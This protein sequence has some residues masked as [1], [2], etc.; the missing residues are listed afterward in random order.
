MKLKEAMNIRVYTGLSEIRLPILEKLKIY[1]FVMQYYPGWLT[2]S[3]MWLKP[4][5]TSG[6]GFHGIHFWCFFIG[7]G[8]EV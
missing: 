6:N 5:Y 7:W 4:K 3:N 2:N 1:N 8:R